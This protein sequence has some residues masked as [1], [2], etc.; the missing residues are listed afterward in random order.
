M[1]AIRSKNTKPELAVR[2]LTHGLGFRFRLHRA[3]LPG[4]PDLTFSRKRKLIFVHG[5]YWHGHGCRAVANPP[6]TN[7]EYWVNKIAYNRER[8]RTNGGKLRAA[9]WRILIIWE[10][11][12]KDTMKVA[13]KIR[14]FLRD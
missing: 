11:E 7:R 12:L 4:K 13:G 2:S 14:Q 6:K 10:C 5:C 3:D 8:D 1:R 9:G